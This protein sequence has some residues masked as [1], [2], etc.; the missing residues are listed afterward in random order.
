MGNLTVSQIVT[1][2]LSLAGFIG[3]ISAIQ[4]F[5]Q[6]I[7]TKTIEDKILEPIEKKLIQQ[8]ERI[9]EKLS[10]IDNKIDDIDVS[11]CRNFLVGFLGKAERG[12]PLDP[13]EVQRAYE[14]MEHY[15]NDLKMNSYIHSRWEEVM[16]KPK[17]G[18]KSK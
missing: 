7:Y 9:N 18:R 16:E 12:E 5:V 6:K 10:K 8:E 14:V 2:V 4:V 15:T 1:Y 11:S 17:K 13:V 3:A